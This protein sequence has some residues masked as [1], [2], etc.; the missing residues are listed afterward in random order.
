MEGMECIK[1]L[2]NN[3][4]ALAKYPDL[5]DY[6][7]DS[8]K[9]LLEKVRDR[10]HLGGRLLSHPLSGGVLPGVSPF[11]SL[12]MTLTPDNDGF[13]TDFD[14]LALIEAALRALKKPPEGFIG[15]DAKTLEDFQVLDLDILD[16]ALLGCGGGTRV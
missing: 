15:Y 3:P 14:S 5:I 12:V 9:V 4:L 7:D 2:T 6:T 11:K 8:V 13:S 1:I 16:S 10:V